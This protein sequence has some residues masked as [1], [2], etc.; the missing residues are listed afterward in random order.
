[1]SGLSARS[2]YDPVDATGERPESCADSEATADFGAYGASTEASS[3]AA[4]IMPPEAR[5][6]RE[7]RESVLDG[8]R[9]T[10]APRS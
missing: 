4:V 1:M 9:G 2:E 6:S 3:I 7:S 5:N 10:A 8:I